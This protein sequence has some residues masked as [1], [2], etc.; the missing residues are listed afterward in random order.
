MDGNGIWK[1]AGGDEPGGTGTDEIRDART[2][3]L[4]ADGCGCGGRRERDGVA[5]R[6]ESVS[7]TG[8]S[9]MSLG[10]LLY[11]VLFGFEVSL[12]Q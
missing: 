11:F 2:A 12:P 9:G 7:V 8:M 1:N 10:E 4:P 6:I 5:M 3:W